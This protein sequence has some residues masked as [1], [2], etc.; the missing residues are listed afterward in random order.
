MTQ[1]TRSLVTAAAV[2][3]LGFASPS[4]AADRSHPKAKSQGSEKTQVTKIHVEP[5]EVVRE[6]NRPSLLWRPPARGKPAGTVGGGGRGTDRDARILTLVPQSVAQ[7]RGPSPSL[8]WHLDGLPGGRLPAGTHVEFTLIDEDSIDPLVDTRLRVHA[9]GIQ[10]IRLSDY[11][12]RLR[13]GIE[14]EW[15]VAIVDAAGERS[16]DLLANGYLERVPAP[17]GVGARAT[18]SA[19]ARHGLWYDA[20]EAISDEIEARPGETRLLA[21]RSQL[22]AQVG[23]PPAIR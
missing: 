18:P 20:L 6:P 8:F 7:T 1:I 3:A 2:T 13:E 9:S 21:Q 12:V 4:L 5:R 16:E 10:R 15:S 14:Y 19:Y 11:G 17:A 23:L 22:L